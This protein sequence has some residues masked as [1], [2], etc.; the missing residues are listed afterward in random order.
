[1][2]GKFDLSVNFSL[3]NGA[4][5]LESGE[6]SVKIGLIDVENEGLK[7]KLRNSVKAFFSMRGIPFSDERCAFIPIDDER[8]KHEISL[9]YAES[10]RENERKNEGSEATM[11]LDTLLTEAGKQGATDIHIEEKRVRFRISARLE[12]VCELSFEKSLELVRRIKVLANLNV[13]ETRHGQDGQFIFNDDEQIF[14]RVSC[15][16]AVS[17]KGGAESVVLRLLNVTRVPLSLSELGFTDGQ[18]AILRNILESEQGLILICGATGSGKSTTAASLL[19]ELSEIYGDKKKIITIEDPPEYVLDG[20]TQI[21][22]DED[23]GMSFSD[24][25]RF[26][27]RQDPDVIYVGEIRDSLSARTVLQASLTG[28][29]VLATVHTSGIEETAIRMRELGVDFTEF[30][31]VLKAMIFQ[32]LV[33]DNAG[34]LRLEAKIVDS[35]DITENAAFSFPS[36]LRNKPLPIQA[37]FSRAGKTMNF[38]EACL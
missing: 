12:E 32:K 35:K 8:L 13:M 11:L 3:Y 9:R 36:K 5:V 22:V 34:S 25:L 33:S 1:M 26:I 31:S 6:D 30:S 18:C 38:G 20:V 23:N 19:M 37:Q 14:V 16:P 21:S 27:F 24:A 10:G 17:G 7:K 2:S 15:V 28:H 29:L 4:V